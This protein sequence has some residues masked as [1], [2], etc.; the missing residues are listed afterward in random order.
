MQHLS[1]CG[2]GY[3]FIKAPPLFLLQASMNLW[4]LDLSAFYIRTSDPCQQ[5]GKGCVEL[6]PVL[7]EC[8][9][10]MS[11]VCVRAALEFFCLL[12]TPGAFGPGWVPSPSPQG[13]GQPGNSTAVCTSDLVLALPQKISSYP[14]NKL[15]VVNFCGSLGRNEKQG[16]EKQRVLHFQHQLHCCWDEF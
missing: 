7:V 12:V 15:P 4:T 14:C 3:I 11:P 10:Q 5:K 8:L 6:N 2:S 16:K 9:A 1:R 13:W